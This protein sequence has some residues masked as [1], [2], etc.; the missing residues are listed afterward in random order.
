MRELHN[1]DTTALSKTSILAKI[2][3]TGYITGVALYCGVG[4]LM[5]GDAA[6]DDDI[7]LVIIEWNLT[8]GG[9]VWLLTFTLDWKDVFIVMRGDISK[10]VKAIA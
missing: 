1:W 9:L 2:L 4:A 3:V 6:N 5:E 7:Y 10:T 8:I